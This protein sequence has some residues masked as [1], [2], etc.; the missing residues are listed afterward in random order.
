MAEFEK[1]TVLYLMKILLEE[2]DRKHMLNADAICERMEKRYHVSCSR[3]TVYRDIEC[4]RSFGFDIELIK[5][6]N[7]GYYLAKRDFELAELEL[8]VDAV[9]AAKFITESKS[10]ELIAK[11]EHLTSS[12]NAKYL[13]RQVYICNRPKAGNET[14]YR[15]VDYIHEAINRNR[16]ISFIYCEWTVAKEL[17][18]KKHGEK[19][20]VSPWSLTWDDENYYLVAYDARADHIKHYRVDKMKDTEILPDGRE[21][22]N[23]FQHFDLA[24]FTKKTFGMFGGTDTKVQLTCENRLAGVMID[25]F[26]REIMMIPKDEGHFRVTVLVT[27]SPQFFGWLTGLGAGVKINSPDEVRSQYREY[28]DSVIR[29][30]I[31]D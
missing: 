30:Y 13:S 24:A 21:G 11:L 18:A 8:L 1:L 23:S 12:Y 14:I 6:S 2:T 15:N 3:K 19:Y 29:Q 27:V 25:R 26:G 9:Q 16:Q 20:M 10:R 28:L 31:L 22:R 7:S 5:G 17:R 4:L